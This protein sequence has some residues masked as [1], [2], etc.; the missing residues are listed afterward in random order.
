VRVRYLTKRQLLDWLWTY[1][2]PTDQ[3]HE[4]AK[5]ELERRRQL[6]AQRRARRDE[7][8]RA[9]ADA[10]YA[11]RAKQQSI[12]GDVSND[13]GSARAHPEALA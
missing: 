3:R 9:E 8:M 10:W 11:E 12:D 6:Q 5:Q 7:R 2:T 4:Y 13:G 1:P